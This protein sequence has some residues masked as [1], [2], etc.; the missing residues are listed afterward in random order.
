MVSVL[1]S[2]YRNLYIKRIVIK[3][4]GL[5]ERNEYP[6]EGDHNRHIGYS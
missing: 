5:W 2:L 6:T 3:S 4:N 1:L